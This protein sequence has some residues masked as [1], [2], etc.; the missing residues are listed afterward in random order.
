VLPAFLRDHWDEAGFQPYRGA[1]PAP[2]RDTPQQLERYV[3]ELA[4]QDAKVA[5]L[6]QLQ[7]LLWQTGYE[8]GAIRAPLYDDVPAAL[9]RWVDRGL[10]VLIY[11]SGSVAAQ[12]L[13][14]Q[15]TDAALAD[16]TPLLSGYYDTVSAGAKQ[17]AASYLRISHAEG[18]APPRW[19]FLS[20]NVKEVEAA[21]RAGMVAIV[22]VR[23]GNAPLDAGVE[24]AHRV[25]DSFGGL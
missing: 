3:S 5:C 7:G 2:A 25:V 20:D 22:V 16:L 9:R 6:K 24:R 15:H 18:I 14:F 11:S 4:A 13:L 21:K 17:D 12:K 23:P 8:T 19:L 10:R 1:F